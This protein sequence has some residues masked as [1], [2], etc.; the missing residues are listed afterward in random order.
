M[1]VEMEE[2]KEWFSDKKIKKFEVMYEKLQNSSAVR[3]G[4]Y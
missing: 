1:P 4:G 3:R 2:G